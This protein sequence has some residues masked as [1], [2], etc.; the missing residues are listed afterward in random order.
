MTKCNIL[1]SMFCS[2]FNVGSHFSV[3]VHWS[4]WTNMSDN[5]FVTGLVSHTTRPRWVDVQNVLVSIQTS[6]MVCVFKLL[7]G[8]TLGLWQVI[9]GTPMCEICY[10]KKAGK[11]CSK[12]PPFGTKSRESAINEDQSKQAADIQLWP[13]HRKQ[14]AP[15][16]VGRVR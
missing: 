1:T 10:A 9:M 7:N 12:G 15:S 4:C 13:P 3:K 11:W 14:E 5:L 6:L 2:C 8:T 16:K